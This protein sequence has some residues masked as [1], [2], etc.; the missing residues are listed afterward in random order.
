MATRQQNKLLQD[1]IKEYVKYQR[2][3]Q[4]ELIGEMKSR[5]NCMMRL[6]HMGI[7]KPE[8]ITDYSIRWGDSYDI[9]RED[10]PRIRKAI[11]KIR[12]SDKDI[13]SEFGK[14][15]RTHI[16]V[17]VRP[18]CCHGIRLKYV[19]ELHESS[20]CKIKEVHVPS[21]AARTEIA[22]VCDSE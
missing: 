15:S 4:E 16:L 17:T 1:T 22:L 10:L 20:K 9:S 5:F 6:M 8:D 14:V 2:L 19:K 13:V 12:V 3:S 7:I 21:V 18:D 11:G